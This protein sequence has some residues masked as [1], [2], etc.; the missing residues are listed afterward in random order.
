MHFSQS[1]LGRAF[2]L[3]AL[4]L[5]LGA[6]AQSEESSEPKLKA[7]T[8]AQKKIASAIAAGHAYEKHVVTEKQFPKVKSQEDFRDLIAQLIANPTHHKKLEN[9][10]EAF[11]DKQSSTIVIYNPR[12]KDKGTCFRPSA[13]L[14]YFRNLK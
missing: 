5:A 11:Y 8:E 13:G 4:V 2:C 10:R 1:S 9:G 3:L 6:C 14:N 7:P 12:A